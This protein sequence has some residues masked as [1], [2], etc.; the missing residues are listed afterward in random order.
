[1]YKILIS[2]FEDTLI[3]NEDAI[4]LSTMLSLDKMRTC[5]IPFTVITNKSFKSILEYNKD[6]PFVDYIIC[7]D[8]AYVY[9]AKESK[10]L[11]HKNIG[12]SIIKKIQKNFALYNLCFYTL[13]WCNYTKKEI[14]KENQRKIGDFNV[15]SKFHKDNIFKIEIHT[16][17][18]KNQLSIISQLEEMDLD[19]EIQ[20]KKEKD[21]FVEIFMKGCSRLLAIEKICKKNHFSLQEVVFI[22]ANLNNIESYKSVGMSIAVDNASKRLK[23]VAGEITVSNNEKAVELAIKK[24]LNDFSSNT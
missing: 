21:Y 6:F 2:D 5:H 8:G 24:Y 4:P 3:D 20:A 14:N 11:I 10:V 18:K 19:I 7:M 9:D 22:G 13:D 23:K 15:F 17:S 12:I 16:S 1:M